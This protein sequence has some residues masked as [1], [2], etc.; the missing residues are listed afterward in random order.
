MLLALNVIKAYSVV[1]NCE[2]CLVLVYHNIV[3]IYIFADNLIQ[4]E[5]ITDKEFSIEN[6]LTTK[7]TTSETDLTYSRNLD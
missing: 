7:N 4:P 2:D 1:T 3:H 5:K 6:I